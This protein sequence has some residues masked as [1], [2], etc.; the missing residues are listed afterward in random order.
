MGKAKD[1]AD[2]KA[3]EK[4]LREAEEKIDFMGH[5]LATVLSSE[6]GETPELKRLRVAGF[7]GREAAAAEKRSG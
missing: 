4:R 7:L 2:G 5:A 3:L 6:V 1:Q